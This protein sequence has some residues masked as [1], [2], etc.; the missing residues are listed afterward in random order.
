MT[1]S[2]LTT[3]VR[4]GEARPRTPIHLVSPGSVSWLPASNE[5]AGDEEKLKT[6]AP[7][8]VGRF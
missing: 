2:R 4:E 6:L 3:A 8:A 7:K 5:S 1:R